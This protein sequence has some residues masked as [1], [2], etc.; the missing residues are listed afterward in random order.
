[1]TVELLDEFAGHKL[2]AGTD[3]QRCKTKKGL[4]LQGREVWAAFLPISQP[5][6]QER[7]TATL[8]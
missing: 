4:V 1:M 7:L 6:E 8:R 2:R 3:N 5:E